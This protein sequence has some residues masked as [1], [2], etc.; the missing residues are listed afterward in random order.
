MIRVL[1]KQVAARIAAGE[2]VERPLSIIKEL[3]ENS[4]DAGATNIVVEIKN[5]GKS[6]IRITDNGQGINGNQVALAF[7]RHATSKISSDNDLKNIHSLGF[8]GEALPSIASVSKLEMITKTKEEKV[9]SKIV[10]QGG[11]IVEKL[12][13]GCPEGTTIIVEDLFFNTPV[14]QKFMKSDSAESGLIIDFLSKISLAYPWLKIR[15]INNNK[16]LFSTPGRGDILQTL[17]TVYGSD[18]GEGLISLDYT[19]EGYSI[20]GY[21][22]SPD[23]SRTNRSFQVFFVN[24][25]WVQ[26]KIMS[27]GVEEAYERR[28][29]DG[30]HPLAFL[31][32]EVE[33]GNLDVNVHPNKKEVRF[34]EE[35]KVVDFISTAIKSALDRKEA[36]PNITVKE[37]IFVLEAEK[38]KT[39]DD[40]SE[41]KLNNT[42]TWNI[43]PG[44]KASEQVDIKSLLSTIKEK[45]IENQE[46]PVPT[47][48]C[49]ATD[50]ELKISENLNNKRF[51]PRDLQALTSIFGTYILAIDS[52]SF[53]MIDQH[54]AH[55]RV[56]F[57]KFMAAY[58]SQE[59]HSQPLLLPFVVNLSISANYDSQLWLD[60][61]TK[62]GFSLAEFG[63]K[64]YRV[65]EIPAFMEISQS[66]S[67]LD[68]FFDNLSES[69]SLENPYLVEKIITRSCKSAV[70]GNDILD[71][72]EI[73]KLLEDLGNCESPYSCPHGRP[74]IIKLTKSDI[75]RLFKR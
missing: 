66:Q 1:E 36:I 5:G 10:I 63:P 22:S 41:P 73:N 54:A 75:E 48:D 31:F 74:T 71:P 21:V 12:P 11:I 40:L 52:D 33:P 69:V 42:N 4:I 43:L 59:F 24:G 16:S 37:N 7:E 6:Y 23:K 57:E 18:I 51:D 44:F 14:R 30:R 61:L 17:A 20:K 27:K 60:V 39:G 32:L 53:Y 58:K 8:R 25:R 64:S 34:E 28:L 9:G 68:F 29:F 56:F 15:F 45:P 67:F 35:L 3:M 55:E 38:P 65:E 70:K 62:M 50:Q 72:L 46:N 19:K 49:S 2:V 47:Q 26:S 13:I